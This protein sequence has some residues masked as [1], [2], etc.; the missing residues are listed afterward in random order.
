MDN[1]NTRSPRAAGRKLRAGMLRLL[2]SPAA[3]APDGRLPD[4]HTLADSFGVSY[5]CVA[6]TVRRLKDEGRVA[7]FPGRGV[8]AAGAATATSAAPHHV[9]LGPMLAGLLAH[10]DIQALRRACPSAVVEVAGELHDRQS[11][12]GLVDAESVLIRIHRRILAPAAEF[13]IGHAEALALGI[14]PRHLE[15]VTLDCR[16]AALPV[17]VNPLLLGLR[18]ELCAELAAQRGS[19]GRIGL[20]SLAGFATRHTVECGQV[21]RRSSGFDFINHTFHTHALTRA[22]GGDW[23]SLEKFY[24]PVTLQALRRL[25]EL[26][27]Q[28]RT[29]LMLISSATPVSRLDIWKMERV[30][31]MFAGYNEVSALL[32]APREFHAAGRDILHWG[33]EPARYICLS[34][35]E[36]VRPELFRAAAEIL[37]QPRIQARILRRGWALPATAN[38]AVWEKAESL[39]GRQCGTLRSILTTAYNPYRIDGQPEA[40]WQAEYAGR[41]Y[42]ADLCDLGVDSAEAVARRREHT[43]QAKQ[44]ALAVTQA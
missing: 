1:R 3:L 20:D 32:H 5:T 8:F 43:M 15:Q 2:S 39:L 4:F 29:C 13:G 16:L 30:A 38:A 18:R 31:M 37:A 11:D 22:A 23:A 41:D 40:F 34:A 36:R 42:L 9:R 19:D 14:E 35:T 33:G 24:G 7:V 44:K 12:L 21:A 27:H 28:A 17:A 6:R 10:A 26:I 25:W